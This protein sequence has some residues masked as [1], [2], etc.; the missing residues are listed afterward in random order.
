MTGVKGVIQ[1]RFAQAEGLQFQGIGLGPFR[2]QRIQ[3]GVQMS[4]V[5]VVVDQTVH[6]ALRCVGCVGSV[7]S[8]G[9]GIGQRRG[10]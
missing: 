2:S 7:R 8:H 9:F 4:N 3:L 6:S 5:S 10:T 1:V